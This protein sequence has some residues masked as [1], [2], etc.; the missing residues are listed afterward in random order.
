MLPSE[1]DLPAKK[2][3][4]GVKVS[5]LSFSSEVTHSC[6]LGVIQHGEP[7]CF[8]YLM[9][10]FSHCLANSLYCVWYTITAPTAIASIHPEQM[11]VTLVYSKLFQAL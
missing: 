5:L 7:S 9:Q 6:E 2:L 11:L 3:E 1:E 4:G 10:F 8:V